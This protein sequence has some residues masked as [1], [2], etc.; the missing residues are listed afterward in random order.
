MWRLY[1]GGRVDKG[2]Q[3]W[4]T[5]GLAAKEAADGEAKAGLGQG[6]CHD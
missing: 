3:S 4:A 1:S 6:P 2:H 5:A